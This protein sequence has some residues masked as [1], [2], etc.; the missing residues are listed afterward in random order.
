MRV[1]LLLT[2]F[3]LPSLAQEPQENGPRKVDPGWHALVARKIWTEPGKVARGVVV[4]RDGRIVSAGDGEPPAGARVWEVDSV[5]AG[6]IDT[7]VETEGDPYKHTHWN[8][9]VAAHRRATSIAEADAKELRQLGFTAAVA[10][11]KTGI[12]RGRASLISLSP[13]KQALYK[14]GVYQALAFERY[15]SGKDGFP[16][17]QMGAIAVLRQGLADG[18]AK[19]EPMAIYATD[20][21]EALR[22]YKVIDEVHQQAIILGSG[23]ELRR[24]NAIVRTE[25]AVILPLNFPDAPDVS[26]VDAQQRADLRALMFWRDAPFNPRLLHENGVT[27]ALTT[28]RLKKRSE[29]YERLRRA[30][31]AGLPES[32]A[33][34][35]L[36]TIPAALVGMSNEMG[37]VKAGHRANLTIVDGDLLSNKARIRAVWI[38]GKRTEVKAPK[39]VVLA[40]KWSVQTLPPRPMNLLIDPENRIEVE[41]AEEKTRLKTVR[42]VDNRIHFVFKKMTFSGIVAGE[43][44]HGHAIDEQGRR[45]VWSA[46][47][48]Q[49]VGVDLVKVKPEP[50][51]AP[52]TLML[53]Y[54]PYGREQMPA[55][56]N[57]VLFRGATIWTSGPQGRIENGDLLIRDGLVAY[58]G[59]QKD[60]GEVEVVDC[61]GKHIT[62]GIIDCHSHT[63]ISKGVND[64]GQ[65]CTAEVRIGD[66]TNPDHI[67]W[68]RQLASGVTTVNSLHGSA[69]PIGGQSQTN[70]VRWG[71]EHPDDMHFFGAPKGIKF[72][73][74]ENVKQSNWGDDYRTRY[75]QTRMGVEAFLRDRFTAAKE[76]TGTPRDLELEALSEI[77]KGER[78]VHCHSYRQDEI[79]MLAR[80]AKEFGFRIGTY[81]HVLEGYKVTDAIK[82]HAI[83][84]SAFSDWWAYKVE[85]QDA[86]PYNGPIMHDA[87]IVVSYNSDSDDLV[88]RLNV[89]AAKA[90]KYGGLAPEEA[91]KFVTI[92]PAIQLGIDKWVGSLEK[93]K[94][95][96][97]AV[98]SGDPLSVYTRCV[99]TLVD[100]MP[101]YSIEQDKEHRETIAR[102]RAALIRE[103]LK[104]PRREKRTPSEEKPTYWICGECGFRGAR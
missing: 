89:E 12:F 45:L 76:Y 34:A 8:K 38:D 85:V 51:P 101:L 81:Q 28:A 78:L 102:D 73:L 30:L 25:A 43:K 69:N 15:R 53:P 21:L 87:G 42:V 50:P 86:I 11:P 64:S 29:F 17:A 14:E 16:T 95:A 83:G 13:K 22:G 74:G 46:N 7:Y 70:K 88:R 44:M 96:D 93:G 23:R 32:A 58:V 63:G 26:S 1:I 84:A 47:R 20:E 52:P 36:T 24:L 4:I 27:V 33:L 104:E 71:V 55:P 67:S 77:L 60:H 72:A 49:Q 54:G 68:Y 65:Q 103:A 56:L 98:W 3:A 91:L 6:L 37:M 75:P 97:V 5:Y 66:V 31:K 90:V 9:K 59:P 18:L 82:A 10:A 80:I 2:L 99:A 61:K 39:P 94:H 48:S 41:E 92:N 79:L 100:G 40:G 19:D 57:N 35:M 62:P